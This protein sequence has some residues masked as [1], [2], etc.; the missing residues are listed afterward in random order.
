MLFSSFTFL[1]AFLP[2]VVAIYYSLKKSWRN[3]F[4]LLSSFIFYG[5]GDP[6]LL[7]LL[8]AVILVNYTGAIIL[9]KIEKLRR[10]CFCCF[11]LLNVGTLIYFKY[12]LFLVKILEEITSVSYNIG[13]IVLPLGISFYIFQAISYLTDVYRK[14]QKAQYNL[15]NLA[16]YIA[17]FPQLIA[18]PIIQYSEINRQIQ[19]RHENTVFMYYG[20]RRFIIGLA[21]KVLVSNTLGYTVSV[22]LSAQIDE[23][24]PFTA[25]YG[26]ILYLFQLYYDFSGYSDMAIGLGYM[27]GFKIPENFDYP[28]ISKSFSEFWRR[29]H[30]SLGRWCKQYIYIPLGGNRCSK[31]RN[32][33]NLFITMFVMGIWHGVG[34]NMLIFAFLCGT[35]V[36][37]EHLLGISKDSDNKIINV[38]KHIYFC[39]IFVFVFVFFRLPQDAVLYIKA[40]LG[41]LKT[42][43]VTHYAFE[44]VNNVQLL[45]LFFAALFVL[46][47][48]RNI[49][50]KNGI[51]VNMGIDLALLC[52]FILSILSILTSSYNPFIYFRF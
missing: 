16:L 46:P 2:A 44:Y 41:L 5:W 4:L 31:L 20:I 38:L 40:M 22:I 42:Q 12:A 39:L 43:Q 47:I 27:F 25:W 36:A 34:W 3:I 1:F 48:G 30:M 26:I 21:K 52:L 11:I 9:S 24:K 13:N 10:V 32:Y 7:S 18:G 6:K 15:V 23:L 49:L 14:T 17:F 35:I 19:S 51:W 37:S 33:L 28:F 8:V 50:R 29:W 45:C